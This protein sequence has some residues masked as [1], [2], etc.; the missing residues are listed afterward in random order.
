MEPKFQSSFIPKGPVAPTVTSRISPNGREKSL[1]SFLSSLIF[2]IS[3]ILA[4]GVFGYKLYLNYSINK[5]GAY[6]VEARATLQQETISELTRLDSR[7]IATGELISKHRILTPLFEFL[8]AS[9][10]RTVRFTGFEYSMTDQGLELYLTGE[11]RGY[12]SLA[13]QADI[14]N[15]SQF[16]K[17]PIFSDLS[18]NDRGDVGFSFRAVLDPSLVS[19]EKTLEGAVL[20]SPATIESQFENQLEDQV[21]TTTPPEQI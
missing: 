13:L 19:Y 9:T 4:V 17:S 15:Q 18:L 7:I 20:P 3:V 21:A 14:F 11:A 16:L 12:E 6:L 1:L 5:M 2:G 10:P 8:E